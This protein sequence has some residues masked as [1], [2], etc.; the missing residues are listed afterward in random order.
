MAL[1][2][3]GPSTRYSGR[4]LRKDTSTSHQDTAHVSSGGGG[5]GETMYRQYHHKNSMVYDWKERHWVAQP[6]V[7]HV[8]VV[9]TIKCNE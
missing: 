6:S 4:Y 8:H 2:S 1:T 7:I 9:T 3:P 5:G